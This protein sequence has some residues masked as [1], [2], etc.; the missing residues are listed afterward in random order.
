[1]LYKPVYGVKVDQA[2][3]G[4]DLWSSR[5]AV[6][7][8][9]RINRVIKGMQVK[10]ISKRKVVYYIIFFVLVLIPLAGYVQSYFN[11]DWHIVY[12]AFVLFPVIGLA[13]YDRYI[14]VD[15]VTRL[16]PVLGHIRYIFE[17]MGI[18]VRNYIV[19][20]DTDGTP[21]NRE[22]RSMVWQRANKMP[23]ELSW[24]TRYR[25]DQVGYIF[26]YHSLVPKEVDSNQQWVIVGGAQCRQ[27]YRSS[28]LNISAMS[29]GSISDHA[30][31][32]LNTGAKIGGFAHNTGEG[33]IS[34]YH[35][36]PGGDLIFQLGTAYFGCRDDQGH[37]DADKFAI[38]AGLD[39]VKMIE[40]KLSQGGKAF[41]WG[42][43][44]RS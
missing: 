27:A 8:M 6:K 34:R 26:A 36:K 12:I 22:Q 35:L 33:G 2:K 20:T 24:G 43:I 21:L 31:L 44:A 42:D 15:S 9:T 16:Y 30:V 10:K 32:A 19:N 14:G 41:T 28:R 4:Y 38:K 5:I 37:F 3:D 17:N 7:Q 18:G 13:F 11:L 23:D 39:A 29:F 40:V 25:V 1:M